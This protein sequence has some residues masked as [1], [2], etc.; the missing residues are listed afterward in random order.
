[1]N[2]N[3]SCVNVS[4]L[5]KIRV[6]WTRALGLHI[7]GLIPERAV[8]WVIGRLRV[9]CGDAGQRDY[10]WPQAGQ[11][12]MSWDFITLL[13]MARNLKLMNCLFLEFSI[14]YFWLQV[15]ETAESETMDRGGMTIHLTN[16]T[17]EERKKLTF[18]K[19]LFCIRAWRLFLSKTA[20]LGRNYLLLLLTGWAFWAE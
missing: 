3:K 10:S 18:V 8:K 4:L 16:Y 11:S 17:L 19:C 2:C 20:L 14:S 13:R 6:I 12:W 15:T 5:S 9:P 7:V 1:M